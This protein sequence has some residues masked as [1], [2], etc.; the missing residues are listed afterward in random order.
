[1]QTKSLSSTEMEFTECIGLAEV[2]LA[3]PVMK[4]LRSSI[5]QQ[6]FEARVTA[7]Q[8]CGYRLFTAIQDE[9]IVGAV[10]FRVVDDLA[11]GHHL[12]IDD[13]VV[14]ESS[15]GKGIGKSLIDFIKSEALIE[16]CTSIRL[17][18]ALTRDDTHRFYERE[19]MSKQS[20]AFRVIVEKQK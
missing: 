17:C 18:S 8:N 1:M 9:T 2:K 5:S 13:L 7:A 19:G 10:G 20:Y 16:G 12:Y 6:E 3:W 4:Q 11:W 14:N 15:R